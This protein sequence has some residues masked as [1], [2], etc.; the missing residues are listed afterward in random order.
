MTTADWWD[1][2]RFGA[3]FDVS[4][5]TVPGWAPVGQE[6]AWYRAHTDSTTRDLHLQTSPLVESLHHQLHRWPHVE[7]YDDFFPLLHFDSFDPDEWTSI[8]RDAGMGYAVMTAKH[9]DGVCWWDAPG[10]DR[11]VLHEGPA[12]NVFGQFAAACERADLALG[13]AYSLLDWAD[14]RYPTAAYVDD[15]LHPQVTDLV[16]RYAIATLRGEAQWGAGGGHWRSDELHAAVKSR[17]PHLIIDDRWWAE[18]ADL[19]TVEHRVPDDIAEQPWEYR[20]PLGASACHNRA[21]PDH[22]MISAAEVASLLTEVVAK[23]GHLMLQVGPDSA[24]RIPDAAVE[25]LRAVG[26]WVRR[27]QRLIDEG[28]PWTRWGDAGSRMLVLDGDLYAIDT[29]GV[30]LFS[31]LDTSSGTVQSIRTLEGAPVDFDQDARGARLRRPPRKSQRM[32]AVY[33][34]DLAPPPPAP[35]ALFT[36]V[37]ARPLDLAP[38]LAGATS[39]SIV[40]LGDGTYLGPVRVPDGVTL[41]GLG[42]ERTTIDGLES[43]AVT[44]GAASRV[45]HCRVTGGGPR[46]GRLPRVAL[47]VNGPDAAAVGCVVDGHIDIDGGS[48]RVTSCTGAGVIARDVDRVDIARCT[49]RGIGTDTGI[50]IAGGSNHHI[51]GCEL[52]GHLAAIVLERTVGAAV[53]HNRVESRW[54]GIRLRDTEATEVSANGAERTMRAVDVD[55]G[56][57][58]VV[59]G[60]FASDGDSGCVVQNGASNVEVTG[61]YWERCRTGLL[62]WEAVAVRDR[63]NTSVELGDPDGARITGPA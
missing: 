5:A 36:S 3:M 8:V 1:R 17:S 37:D 57:G 60:N 33:R 7:A 53:R 39:G 13:A 51:D 9:H 59:T 32:P 19:L 2:R 34:I 62:V 12:R 54:W 38:L 56:T 6:A 45:E 44:L 55:G 16:T 31:T 35:I 63:G 26:G 29:N 49:F 30:G 21:E 42:A 15:V 23:G 50:D 27:H 14:P 11:T 48:T 40:Q 4:L 10:T 22:L 24:G 58:A 43:A 61:N 25:R 28:R 46:I 20:R 18:S 52:T 47:R 41:R